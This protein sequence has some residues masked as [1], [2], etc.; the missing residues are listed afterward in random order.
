MSILRKRETWVRPASEERKRGAPAAGLSPEEQRNLHAAMQFLRVRFGS[1][2]AIADVT[3]LAEGTLCAK[4]RDLGP[5][6]AIRVARAAGEPLEDI[7][8]GKWPRAGA[9]AHCGRSTPET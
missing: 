9:C 6:L 1:W 5:G 4:P 7:L 8:T 2:K 3:G